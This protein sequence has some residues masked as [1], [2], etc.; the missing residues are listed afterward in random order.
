[1]AQLI[2]ALIASH[3]VVTEALKKDDGKKVTLIDNR[4]IAKPDKFAG[5]DNERFLRWKIKLITF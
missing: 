1:M 3:T 4:G 2:Q 5:K